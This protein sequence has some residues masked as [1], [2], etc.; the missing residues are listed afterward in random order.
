MQPELDEDQLDCPKEACFP[1]LKH[2]DVLYIDV[3]V[4]EVFKNVHEIVRSIRP[5]K[6]TSPYNW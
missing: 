4:D 3:V 6:I 1:L 2:H 5:C